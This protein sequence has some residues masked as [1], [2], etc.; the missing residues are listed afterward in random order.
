MCIQY[1]SHS[2]HGLELGVGDQMGEGDGT[3]HRNLLATAALLARA[4]RAFSIFLPLLV[5][6]CVLVESICEQYLCSLDGISNDLLLVGRILY[7]RAGVRYKRV[8]FLG[9]DVYNCQ[10]N[11][12]CA[13]CDVSQ[14]QHVSGTPFVFCQLET[15][16]RPLYGHLDLRPCQLGW[17]R[18][19]DN[20]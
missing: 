20:L 5:S 13:R 16:L 11:W 14:C 8:L 7:S 19:V 2:N 18:I 4:F 12:L 9:M 6:L 3:P 10:L 1:N 15:R 17:L